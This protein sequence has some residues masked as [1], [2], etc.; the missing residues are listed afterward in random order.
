MAQM[1]HGKDVNQKALE[2]KKIAVLGYGSQGRGQS[3]NLR[4]SGVNVVLG[5]RENGKSWSFAKMEG[6][7]PKSFAEAVKDA[8]IIQMLVP[9]MALADIF[10]QYVEPNMKPGAMLMFSHGFA[11]TYEQIKPSSTIDVTMIAPKG[12]GYLVRTEYE[13]GAG[14]PALIAVHQDVSGKAKEL[15]LAYAHAI[16]ATRGGVLETTFKDETETDLFGEQAVLCGGAVELIK[17]GWE[18]LVKA[19]YSAELAYFEC[20]HELK[21]IVDLLYD[22]GIPRMY[23][24]V[25][26]TAGYGAASRGPRIIGAES[27]KAMEEI[28]KEI[29][30]GNFAK[31]WTNEWNSGGKNFY[32]MKEQ[33]NVHPIEK[34]GAD[35]R[36]HM[37]WLKK[38]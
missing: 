22:G 13:K 10:T 38:D 15:A 35:V 17:Q 16:G 27:R 32:A 20:L 3:L 31:E 8:D 1:Y 21:L 2:G 25:S 33:E 24:F 23:R 29:Q 28:L 12:P 26:D 30:N 5:L 6:W 18:T 4:D 19:G 7:E 34:V 36:S 9:D 37:S 11:I 14:V